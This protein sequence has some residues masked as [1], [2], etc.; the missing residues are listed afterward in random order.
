MFSLVYTSRIH[1]EEVGFP[2]IMSFHEVK[3]ERKVG[4]ERG[5]HK[6]RERKGERSGGREE[7]KEKRKE[8]K[9]PAPSSGSLSQA[10]LTELS[11][12]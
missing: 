10:S 1:K 7:G 3:K 11:I 5:R 12:G 4:K 2:A 9:N 6:E 8:K